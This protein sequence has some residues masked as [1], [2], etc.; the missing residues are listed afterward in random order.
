MNSLPV[1][2]TDLQLA[3][4]RRAHSLRDE[5]LDA[6]FASA[7]V[8]LRRSAQRLA[9]SLGRHRRLRAGQPRWG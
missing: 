9:A 1:L 3:A 4:Q 2:S 6:V 8:A 5:A 7:G